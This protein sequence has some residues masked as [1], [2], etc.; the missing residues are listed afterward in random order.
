MS[1]LSAS[2]LCI[3]TWSLWNIPD[4]SWLNC[5]TLHTYHKE[6]G[7]SWS[8]VLCCCLDEHI[9]SHCWKLVPVI[10]H[11][12]RSLLASRTYKECQYYT[13]DV[14]IIRWNL[15]MLHLPF[16][17][18]ILVF[19]STWTCSDQHRISCRRKKNT[20]AFQEPAWS[21]E[22]HT[23]RNCVCG[24]KCFLTGICYVYNV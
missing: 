5:P 13:A 9:T 24:P 8:Y 16:A 11:H 12:A 14:T 18:S 10:Q 19:L 7:L 4:F 21:T 2:I 3:F 6:F 1:K 15:K 20:T 17:V 22:V 23:F